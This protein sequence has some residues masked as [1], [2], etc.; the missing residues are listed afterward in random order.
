VANASKSV[1]FVDVVFPEEGGYKPHGLADAHLV[2]VGDRESGTF[3]T[4][5]LQGV[6][7]HGYIPHDGIAIVDADDAAFFV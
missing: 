5:V 2:S 3:L 4:A 7:P 6:K 1:K